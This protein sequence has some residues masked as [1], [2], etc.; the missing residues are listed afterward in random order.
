MGGRGRK[1][2]V[3]GWP[4]AKSLRLLSAKWPKSVAQVVEHLPSKGKVLSLKKKKKLLMKH[5]TLPPWELSPSSQ[6]CIFLLHLCLHDP[7]S[8][9]SS[10][11]QPVA[12]MWNSRAQEAGCYLCQVWGVLPVSCAYRIGAAIPTNVP[13]PGPHLT[14]WSRPVS[15]RKGG[16]LCPR[17]LTVCSA[18][19]GSTK[20]RPT[21]VLST[22]RH[23]S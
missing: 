10:L 23:A 12:V 17:A 15:C 6:G 3:W 11:L 1:I 5:L 14:H 19:S 8:L 21:P 4:W 20:C 22:H 7:V 16:C 2:W 9:L 13:A 18:H